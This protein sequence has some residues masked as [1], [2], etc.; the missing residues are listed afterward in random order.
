MKLL[1][2][3]NNND[4]DA[5]KLSPDEKI[6]YCVPFDLLYDTVSRQVGEQYCDGKQYIVV[7]DKRML[8]LDAGIIT[9]EYLL[10]EC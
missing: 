2:E 8:V 6:W 7:T 10:S 1:Y 5:L 4:K 3:L 9:T